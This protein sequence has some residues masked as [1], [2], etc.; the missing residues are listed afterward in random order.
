ME[1]WWRGGRVNNTTNLRASAR[2]P[3]IDASRAR[4]GNYQRFSVLEVE[5]L[6][7]RLGIGVQSTAREGTHATTRNTATKNGGRVVRVA[8]GKVAANISDTSRD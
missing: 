5:R 4:T 3:G 2:A 8:G 6:P 1:T 7:D